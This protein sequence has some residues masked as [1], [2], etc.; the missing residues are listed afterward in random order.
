ME[1][2]W[3]RW[4]VSSGSPVT[5]VVRLPISW[6]NSMA[7]AFHAPE[8][9]HNNKWYENVSGR[10]IDIFRWLGWCCMIGCSSGSDWSAIDVRVCISVRD[11]IIIIIIIIM[12]RLSGGFHERCWYWWLLQATIRRND[13]VCRWSHVQGVQRGRASAYDWQRREA[14]CYQLMDFNKLW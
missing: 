14:N 9:S 4:M 12:C 7:W 3:Q 1:R 8:L 2:R 10:K 13:V 5:A 11:S 6:V